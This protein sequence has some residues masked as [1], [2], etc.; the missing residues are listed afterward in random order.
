MR[1]VAIAAT[2]TVASSLLLAACGGTS[3][4]DQIKQIITSYGVTPTKLCTEY[5]TPHMIFQQFGSKSRCLAA[6]S[7][8]GAAD[9]YVKVDSVTVK[10]THCDR[11]EDERIQPRQGDPGDHP[12]RQDRVG[13]EGRR[14]SAEVNR[15]CLTLGRA[16]RWDRSRSLGSPHLMPASNDGYRLLACRFLRAARSIATLIALAGVLTGPAAAGAAQP[17][18]LDPAFAG[19]VVPTSGVQLFGAAERADGSVV[20][21]GTDGGARVLRYTAGGSLASS[22][23]GAGLV[24]RGVAIDSGGNA[25]VA[26]GNAA[27]GTGMVVERFSGGGLD[28]SFGSKG[29]VSLLAGSRGVAN[30][31]AVDPAGKIVVA[32]SAVPHRVG[33]ERPGWPWPA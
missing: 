29:V 16:V 28:S 1:R 18:Q 23:G 21:S 9:P 12:L 26:G 33:T 20:A 10:G 3:D 22:A 24:A 7:S 27:S 6:A 14:G 4:E 30:A 17:G 15:A 31:V 8:V 2:C 13:L 19:G 5:A 11:R 25:V 32:G